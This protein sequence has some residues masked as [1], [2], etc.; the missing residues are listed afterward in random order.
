LIEDT[1]ENILSRGKTEVI[2]EGD[3]GSVTQEVEDYTYE[4]PRFLKR[5]GLKPEISRISLKQNTL[6]EIFLKLITVSEKDD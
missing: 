6:E 4:L 1:P 5:Y 2:V 3:A